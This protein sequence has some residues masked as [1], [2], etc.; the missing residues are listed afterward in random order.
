MSAKHCDLGA[1]SWCRHPNVT[2]RNPGYGRSSLYTDD[3]SSA[4]NDELPVESSNESYERP[5]GLIISPRGCGPPRD[6]VDGPPLP[7]RDIAAGPPSPPRVIVA[8]PPSPPRDIVAGPPPPPGPG[9][10]GCWCEV[11]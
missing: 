11:D 3:P 6:I 10:G 9:N 7:T 4:S 2:A 1:A 8:G 5:P